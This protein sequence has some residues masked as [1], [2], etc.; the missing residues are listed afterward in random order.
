MLHVKEQPR[1]P[2]VL[3]RALAQYWRDHGASLPPLE[4]DDGS[5]LR[6]LYAGRASSAAGPDFRD[7]VLQ[8]EGGEVVR[9][10]VELHLRR[11]GWEAHGHH[12]D[13]GYDGVVLHMV[14][15]GGDTPIT[16]ASGR[17]V[18][19]ASLFPRTL[20]RRSRREA[21][22]PRPLP[23]A[24]LPASASRLGR[25]LDRE[26]DARFFEKVRGFARALRQAEPSETL[27][28]G[29]MG[30]L[31]Y[32]GNS[33]PMTRLAEGMPLRA[34][35]RALRGVPDG[36]R[37]DALA[38]ALVR[39]SG[40]ASGD[41]DSGVQAVEPVLARGEWKLFRVRPSNHPSRRLMGMAALLDRAW[42]AGLAGWAATLVATGSVAEVRAG[43]T[44]A[45]DGPGGA[46]VGADRASD[47]AVN[48]VLPFARA[49]GNVVRDA[50]I[51][52]A[53]LG[54]YRAW[55]SLQENSVTA[56]AARLLGGEGKELRRS[57]R[58]QQGL[59]RVYRRGLGGDVA[60]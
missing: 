48:V 54:L 1:Q 23:L 29:L 26:G 53:A 33:G 7:A 56:E 19:T 14:L 16:L 55:P 8:R 43:L 46:L 18:P 11:G 60:G 59:I 37:R 21:P 36:G 24:S 2:P 35:E 45:G 52:A 22:T 32:G 47:L 25:T 42:D 27:Y 50:G 17:R 20:G 30:G 41:G 39:A 5:R 4:C 15:H 31:G 10:D 34:L 12:T 51:A 40:L 9:G 28:A 38:S 49:W 58:R 13:R 3:E 6:V 44:V 57:A